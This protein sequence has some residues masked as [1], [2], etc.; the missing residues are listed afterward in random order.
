[1]IITTKLI[2]SAMM[3]ISLI[4]LGIF[5]ILLSLMDFLRALGISAG[6]A[7]VMIGFVLTQITV[8]ED[9]K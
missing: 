6:V 4:W 7:L 9:T 5:S 2:K 8:L 1:M 3:G